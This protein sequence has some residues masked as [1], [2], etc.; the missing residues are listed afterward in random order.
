[1]QKH[2]TKTF[3]LKNIKPFKWIIIGQIIVAIIWAIDLSLR[4]YLL[5]IMLDKLAILQSA[6]AVAELLAPAIFY[7]GM[8]LLITIVF[9]F[10]DYL[11]LKLNSGLKRHLG[12]ILMS[13]MMQHSQGLFQN[14]FAGNI[15]NKIKD[16]MSGVPDLIAIIVDQFL[17]HS[18]SLSV[19]VFAVWTV[20]F[21]FA[22]ALCAWVTIFISGSVFLSIHAKYLCE[23]AADVRSRVVG[24][25]VDIL[26]NMMNVRL[27]SGAAFEEKKLTRKLDKYVAADQ[28]RD[29][30]FLW[31]F[32]FQGLS[33]VIYQG[34]CLFWL[35]YG[36]RDGVVT[37]GDFALIITINIHIIDALWTLSK[38][39]SRYADT[40]GNINQGLSI[41][42]TPLEI[43]DATNA[44]KLIITKG[45]IAFNNVEFNY[46]NTDP[47]FKDKNIIIHPGQKVGLV[48]YSGS[49]KST[50]V[51]LIL[52]IFDV[53]SGSITIDNQDIRDVTQESLR[54]NIG[55]IPQDPS[56]FHRS[57]IENIRY[58]K[59]DAT[60]LEVILAAKKAFAHDFIEK[61]P[62]GY[63]SLAG[64][65]GVKL[66]GGQRQRIA[67][68]RA[69]LKNA[70]ILILDE[71][72]SQLDSIT[73]AEIQNSLL[74][75]MQTVTDNGNQ[76]IAK[77]VLVV[78]HRLSTLLHMDRILV[79]NDGKIIEDGTHA[80]LL[81]NNGMYKT[82]WDAQIGGLL[83]DE[84]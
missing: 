64:E 54:N 5:K 65:R 47:L 39:I 41:V 80:E 29:W 25:I 37:A 71:A 19:A 40:L 24:H 3:I 60:D 61:L 78:A 51:N 68:A 35:I 69:I 34:V 81:A 9:R 23:V 12:N 58:A 10:H 22:L 1:M 36:F 11:W 18:L 74:E 6:N 84:K 42:Y 17:A 45:E 73:E 8:S 59:P 77:T 72:T 75:L 30:Y 83:P 53:T 2:T 14:N 26:S 16:V 21:K 56:L 43:N 66:S 20:N 48:G 50:F 4:P 79:F 52:R 67:I 7:I 55:M 82:L 31:M 70:P 13:R 63:H 76:T 15:G 28:N 62:A 33:F 32:A 46:E 38:D 49:G 27:F 57:L 44:Q